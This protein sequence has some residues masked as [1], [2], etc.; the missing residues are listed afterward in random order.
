MGKRVYFMVNLDIKDGKLDAFK[1]IAQAMIAVTVAEPGALAYEWY[2]SADRTRCRLVES[3]ADE[4]AVLAHIAG[5][6]VAELVPKLLEVSNITGFEVYGDTGA[7]AAETLKSIRR[8][9]VSTLG[10]T[11]PLMLGE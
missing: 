11:P 1:D 5:K 4:N 6:A 10:R 3:Y 8:R 2:F 9:A 7:K